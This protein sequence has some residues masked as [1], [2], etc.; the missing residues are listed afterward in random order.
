MTPDSPIIY[1]N[2]HTGKEET[3]LV[4]G[5]Q[6]IRQTYGTMKGRLALHL[7]IKR[8]FFSRLYGT[9]MNKPASAR[10][11]PGFIKQFGINMEEA[12]T[13]PGG[14]ANFNEFFY[15]QLKPG[16]RPVDEAPEHAV[17]PADGRHSGFQDASQVSGVFVKGQT[18]DIPALLG[19]RK[20]GKRYAH[21][22]LIIS[23]LCPVDYHR[24]HF[25]VEG[26]PEET[27][28]I[29]GPLA[30]VSPYALRRRLSWLWTNKRTLTLLDSPQWGKVALIDVGA[31]CVGS[32]FQTFTPGRPVDKGAEKG[33]FA[34]GGSTVITLFEPGRIQLAQD[35]LDC[36]ARQQE[37]YA[38]VGSFMGSSLTPLT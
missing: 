31:T 30:S 23:R 15:R 34:F 13:P 6:A 3:E 25:P 32:I 12:S 27:R 36:S 19:D 4:L 38:R 18:F 9:H 33:Y 5:E 1:F 26:T 22:S 10:R 2:R 17:F 35:L 7:L 21:G 11:I 24:F 37:L 28:L 16:A 14:F 8:A 20:L 29:P